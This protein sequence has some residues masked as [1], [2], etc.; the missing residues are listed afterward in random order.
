[1]ARRRADRRRERAPADAGASTSPRVSA[2]ACTLLALAYL[3]ALLV[4]YARALSGPFVSDDI[5]YVGAN[6]YVHGLSWENVRAILLPWG[7]AT[8]AVVNYSPVQLLLH[9]SVWQLAGPELFWHHALTLAFHAATSALFLPLLLRSGVPPTGAVLGSLLFLLHPANVEAAAW[10]SQ[11]KSTAGLALGFG[12]VLAHPRRPLL[13]LALFALA[14]LTKANAAAVL[15]LA[16]WLAWSRDGALRPRWLAAWLLVFAA[17]A[18]VEWSAHQRAGAA[19]ALLH[20]TPLVLLR[21]MA[22]LAARYLV[23]AATSLGLSAFHE[24]EPAYSW[25]APWWLASLPLLGLLGWRTWHVVRARRPEAGWWLFALISFGP[26]SQIFPFL[27]PLA[28]RYLYFILPG[29]IGGT[30]CALGE[31]AER[32]PA[33][34]RRLAGRAALALGVALCALFAVRTVERAALWR[35]PFLLLADAARNY[36]RGVSAHLSLARTAAQAGDAEATAEALRV[37]LA[38]GYN[39]FE[40]LTSDPVYDA[41]RGSAPFRAVLRDM[42]AVWIEAGSAWD[43]PTQ[44]ELRRLASAHALRGERD[45]AVALL[46]RAL[47]QGGPHDA[48]IR[49]DLAALG[50]SPGS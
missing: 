48:A 49:E 32:V 7:P 26:V 9:A 43:S 13:A 11:L 6:P 24:P 12:A 42:A 8:V 5:H 4:L 41:V 39:R 21:T 50:A 2:G 34:Q 1:M 15:P 10:I 19:E 22:A 44:G 37:A 47:V 23:M 17:F 28:D 46:R 20:E 27:Y 29:L 38:R 30:L 40:Q 3:G 35:S 33:S 16:F 31:L 14:L 45:A 36:P 18:L 25:L